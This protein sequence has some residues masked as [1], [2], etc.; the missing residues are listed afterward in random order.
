MEQTEMDQSVRRFRLEKGGFLVEALLQ[1]LGK[2]YL[3]SIWGGEAHIGAVAMAQPRP[4]LSDPSRPS[5]TASVFCYVGHKEDGLVKAVSEWLAS[6]LG[7]KVVVTAGLHWDDLTPEGIRQV[8][9]NVLAL[10]EMIID[11]ERAGKNHE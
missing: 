6:A 2:D 1:C 7:A 10:A 3:L 4:S 11:E 9:K 8:E 5:A